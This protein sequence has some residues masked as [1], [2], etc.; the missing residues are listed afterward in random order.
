MCFE[1]GK[2]PSCGVSG[3]LE[4]PSQ[5][6]PFVRRR[7]EHQRWSSRNAGPGHNPVPATPSIH[8]Y[9][10]SPRYPHRQT[11]SAPRDPTSTSGRT[12]PAA[13]PP[14]PTP[15]PANRM[16]GRNNRSTG[17]GEKDACLPMRSE[18]PKSS[19][20]DLIAVP[21]VTPLKLRQDHVPA[22]DMIQDRRNLHVFPLVVSSW[23]GMGCS[24][25]SIR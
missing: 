22:V 24:I 5:K 16:A 2:R 1:K 17:S 25:A 14:P 23:H 18:Q 10:R 11:A 6:R 21:D 8:H 19:S 7:A 3:T 15:Y 12:V 13:P 9:P 4:R 20:S